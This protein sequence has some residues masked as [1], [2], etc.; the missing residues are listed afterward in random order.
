MRRLVLIALGAAL[1]P[2]LAAEA[3]QAGMGRLYI[4][5]TPDPHVGFDV[6]IGIDGKRGT[7][8][9]APGACFYVDL[10][11]GS[12]TVHA[13]NEHDPSVDLAAGETKYVRVVTTTKQI[14]QGEMDQLV[15]EPVSRLDDTS[16]CEPM[17][18]P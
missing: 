1:A 9:L 4:A 13:M 7:A 12:H 3:P 5:R 14:G 16:T 2:A 15:P 11:P 17:P 18:A 10:P 8:G 6:P